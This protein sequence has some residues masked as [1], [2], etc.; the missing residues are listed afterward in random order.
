MTHKIARWALLLTLAALIGVELHQINKYKTCLTSNET[1]IT[2]NA[3][4]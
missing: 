1:S 2:N 3:T 4:Y